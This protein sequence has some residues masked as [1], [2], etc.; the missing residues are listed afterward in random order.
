MRFEE[1]P[2]NWAP[3]VSEVLEMVSLVDSKVVDV[4]SVDVVSVD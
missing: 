4:I 3:T 1:G 2:I